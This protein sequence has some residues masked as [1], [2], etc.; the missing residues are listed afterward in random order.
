[1]GVTGLS[2]IAEI[3]RTP[4]GNLRVNGGS[5][6]EFVGGT[7]MDKNGVMAVFEMSK[8]FFKIMQAGKP[9]KVYAI[10]EF[11]LKPPILR[12]DQHTALAD[13]FIRLIYRMWPPK[14]RQRLQTIKKF[15]DSAAKATYWES[16]GPI[17]LPNRHYVLSG[18][19]HEKSAIV[20][21]VAVL[22]A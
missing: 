5:S 2:H 12:E 15:G 6:T 7:V 18:R 19:C 21:P 20:P 10:R 3:A 22:A 1:V 4:A 17:P 14:E 11:G 8:D 9:D 13:R 16:A